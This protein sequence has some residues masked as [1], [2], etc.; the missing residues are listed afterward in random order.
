[1]DDDRIGRF[2]RGLGAGRARGPAAG[3]RIVAGGLIG[4]LAQAQALDGNAEPRR[5][6]HREHGRMP[7]FG[8]PTRQP[9][10][11]I[12]N[13]LAGGRSLDAHLVLDPRRRGRRSGP[14]VPPSGQEL[15]HEE[16]A[17]AARCRWA[18][19]AAAPAPDGGCSR[20]RSCSPAEMKILVPLTGRLPS[21]AARPWSAPDRDRCRIAARSGT[22]CRPMSRRRASAEAL[23][24]L[25]GAVERERVVRRPGSG[26]ETCRRRDSPSKSSPRLNWSVC[27]SPCP[28]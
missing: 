21:G 28:P 5:V 3:P 4:S 19:P 6:H 23:L 8:S 27:G 22:W 18:R 10:G 17:D 1:M 25:V 16:Q 13:D 2:V 26:P 7:L 24:L 11:A 9:V 14:D 12:E 20:V 15:G